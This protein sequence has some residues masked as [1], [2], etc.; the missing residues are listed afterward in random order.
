MKS[1][2]APDSIQSQSNS[3]KSPLPSITKIQNKFDANS[4]LF[5]DFMDTYFRSPTQKQTIIRTQTEAMTQTQTS[6]TEHT[7]EV[8]DNNG[9]NTSCY[10]PESPSQQLPQNFAQSRNLSPLLN[11]CPSFH[12]E[13]DKASK[14]AFTSLDQNDMVSFL[15]TQ[16]PESQLIFASNPFNNSFDHGN[17]LSS[18]AA[19]GAEYDSDDNVFS[20]IDSDE[21]PEYPFG[22]PNVIKPPIKTVLESEMAC[23]VSDDSDGDYILSNY[24]SGDDDCGPVSN[25][26]GDCVLAKMEA[27]IRENLYI[28]S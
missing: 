5:E 21:D 10:T 7:D 16:N 12:E 27:V 6:D 2:V 19:V 20:L 13:T 8:S 3:Q 23:I 14:A 11:D 26:E 17:I 18:K 1:L 4:D 28:P 9:D 25:D 15:Q 22:T 24:E